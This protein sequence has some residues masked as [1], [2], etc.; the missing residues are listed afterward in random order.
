MGNE[1]ILLMGPPGAGKGTQAARL[2]AGRNLKQLST[3]DI[4]R[5]NVAGGTELGIKA[6]GFMDAGEL[7]P[8]DLIID[9]VRGEL[10]DLSE[11]RVLFDGY[12]RNPAQAGQL[13]SLLSEL[14][15]ELDAAIALDVDLDEVVRRLLQR[16]VEQGR[17]DDN[18]STIRHRLKVY[19]EQTQPLFDYYEAAGKLRRVDGLGAVEEVEQRIAG[20]LS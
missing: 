7:V 15:A 14:G 13:D 2:A 1:V 11:V 8:D 6:K 20:E 16:A 19:A 10:A 17:S 9:M 4:L 3:G 12:P 5:A 18:E